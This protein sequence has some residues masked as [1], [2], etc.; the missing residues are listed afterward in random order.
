MDDDDTLDLARSRTHL[1]NQRTYAAWLRTGLAVAAA[2]YAIARLAP[3]LDPRTAF[4][5][6]TLFV[7]LGIAIILFGAWSYAAER[8]AL[9]SPRLP[10]AHAAKWVVYGSALGLSLLLAA[11]LFL[12]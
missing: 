11:A 10:A 7:L 6:G 3:A 1:A 2:G 4:A 5:L 12:V 8:R 9:P